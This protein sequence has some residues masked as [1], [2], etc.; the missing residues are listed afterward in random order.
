[1]DP[2]K[3]GK[4]A[5]CTLMNPPFHVRFD[6]HQPCLLSLHR[7]GMKAALKEVYCEQF[8]PVIPPHFTFSVDYIKTGKGI[9]AQRCVEHPLDLTHAE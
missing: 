5:P 8:V 3:D 1:M 6:A 9:S 4:A 7:F 2:I